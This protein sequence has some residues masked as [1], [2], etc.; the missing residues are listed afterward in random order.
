MLGRRVQCVS[1]A[2]QTVLPGP[3]R[4]PGSSCKDVGRPSG[5]AESNALVPDQRES[6][7]ETC[8]KQTDQASSDGATGAAEK[9]QRARRGTKERHGSGWPL[10]SGRN[11]LVPS[12]GM[13][14]MMM[15]MKKKM[16]MCSLMTKVRFR[17]VQTSTCWLS[18]W[19]RRV[20]GTN[21]DELDPDGS[22]AT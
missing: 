21:W 15:K 9:T 19:R 8:N 17:W 6:T 16:M 11:L 2:A 1:R 4:T 10:G 20:T 12:K 5:G 22:P 3:S 13:K 7:E 14:M 18:P